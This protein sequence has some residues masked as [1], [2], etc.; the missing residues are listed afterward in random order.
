MIK[1]LSRRDIRALKIG[2]VCGAAILL[3]VLVSQW[4]GYWTEVKRSLN[5][6]RDRLKAVNISKAKRVG[7]ATIVPAFEMPQ[8]EEKQKVLFRRKL[9]EQLEKAGIKAEALQFMRVGK[10]RAG[11][12]KLLR[13]QC[14]RGKCNFGQAL[15]FLARLKENPYLVGIEELEMR[16][17]P[18]KRQEFELNLTVSTYLK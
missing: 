9:K 1:K 11:G 14:R 18:K 7:L 17:N 16:C 3:F 5:A 6:R 13:L 4:L 10:S 8:E 2:A 15:D 12:Y